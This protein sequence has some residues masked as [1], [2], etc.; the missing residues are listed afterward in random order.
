GME[1]CMRPTA[2]GWDGPC[3]WWQVRCAAWPWSR[4]EDAWG[5]IGWIRKRPRSVRGA[6]GGGGVVVVVSGGAVVVVVVMLGGTG[7]APSSTCSRGRS[8][9]TVLSREAKLASFGLVPT[10]AS[11]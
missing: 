10:I 11:E 1:L 2:V 4:P 5:V 3:L 7:T 8:A 9:A 6:G